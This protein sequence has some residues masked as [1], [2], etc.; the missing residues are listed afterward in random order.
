[1]LERPD[2]AGDRHRGFYQDKMLGVALGDEQ[3]QSLVFLYG[4][5]KDWAEDE[6]QIAVCLPSNNLVPNSIWQPKGRA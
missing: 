1:M 2:M 3:L 5:A 4:C 6:V